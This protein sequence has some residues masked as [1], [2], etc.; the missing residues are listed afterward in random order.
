MSEID[1]ELIVQLRQ[2]S[3]LRGIIMES[4]ANLWLQERI[5]TAKA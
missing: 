4:L 5:L 3:Q 1:P 2:I